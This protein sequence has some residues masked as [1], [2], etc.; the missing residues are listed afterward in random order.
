MGPQAAVS[1]CRTLGCVWHWESGSG[2]V[3][4]T[5]NAVLGRLGYTRI[6]LNQ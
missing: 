3:K 2:E 6:D 1:V 4:K 5:S